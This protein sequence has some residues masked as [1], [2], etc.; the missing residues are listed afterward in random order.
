MALSLLG[1]TSYSDD[2]S[3]VHK[4]VHRFLIDYTNCKL[5]AAVVATSPCKSVPDNKKSASWAKRFSLWSLCSHSQKVLHRKSQT[6]GSPSRM[7][8]LVASSPESQMLTHCCSPFLAKYDVLV[9]FTPPW[10]PVVWICHLAITS[11]SPLIKFIEHKSVAS[12]CCMWKV[13]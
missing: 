10:M 13:T 2:V 9:L 11:L 1:V 5:C 8:Q 4:F 12:F 3:K 6:R 7:G